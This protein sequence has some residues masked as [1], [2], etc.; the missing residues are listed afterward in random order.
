MEEVKLEFSIGM[1][2][3]DACEQLHNHSMRTGTT[4]YGIFNLEKVTS[5]MTLNEMYTAVTGKSK[6]AQEI[7]RKKWAADYERRKQEHKAAIPSLIIEY[8]NKGK[9]ILKEKYWEKWVSCLAIRL[10]DLYCGAELGNLLDLCPS[11]DAR[12]FSTAHELFMNQGHSVMSYSLMCSMIEEF[13]DNGH[14][15]VLYSLDQ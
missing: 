15:F 10:S 12:D 8:T 14:D 9:T 3:D 13:T 6:T 4:C 11:I 5:D 7:A 1:S 2:I